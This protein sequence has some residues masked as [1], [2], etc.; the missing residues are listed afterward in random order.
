[1]L[2]R[3]IGALGGTVPGREK[4]EAGL[5]FSDYGARPKNGV[6]RL[7]TVDAVKI[8]RGLKQAGF[9]ELEQKGSHLMLWHPATRRKTVVPMHGG[10]VKRGLM[11]QILKQAGL[12]ETKFRE[13]I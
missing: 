4:A 12:S 9:V 5:Q 7:P 13:L 2:S 6:T 3:W 1:V 10:D 8:L 11:K